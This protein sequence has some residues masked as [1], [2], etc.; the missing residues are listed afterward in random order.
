[1]MTSIAWLSALSSTSFEVG[2]QKIPEL[3]FPSALTY[4][5]QLQGVALVVENIGEEIK[6]ADVVKKKWVMHKNL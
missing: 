6:V 1:M 2:Y 4:K 3:V 5:N